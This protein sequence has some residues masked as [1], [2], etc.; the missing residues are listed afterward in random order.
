MFIGTHICVLVSRDSDELGLREDEGLSF[1]GLEGILRAVLLDLHDVETRLVLMEGL[2][3][4]HLERRRSV[5]HPRYH[6][7]YST[8]HIISSLSCQTAAL[9]WFWFDFHLLCCHY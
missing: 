7:S 4:D 3:H 6:P 2:E 1:G 8:S 9:L 5:T